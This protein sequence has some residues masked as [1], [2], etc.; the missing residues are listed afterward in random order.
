MKIVLAESLG[1]C[2]GVNRAVEATKRL[3]KEKR[4]ARVIGDIVHNEIVMKKLKD[5]GLKVYPDLSS[6][7]FSDTAENSV[8]IIRAHGASPD[9][10]DFLKRRFG[11]VVDLT[12][13]IVYNV[14]SLAK[15]LEKKGYFIVIFGKKDHAEVK[16]LCGRLNDYLIVEPGYDFETIKAF[17]RE[18]KP[19][20][21]ALISQTTM[22]SE[23]FEKLAEK[24]LKLEG[25]EVSVNNTICNVTINR[26]KMAIH[27]AQTCDAVV[28]VGG[29][30]S[31]NTGKLAKIVESHGK[32]AFHVQNPEQLPDLS[33]YRKVGIISGTSTPKEQI[34]KILDYIKFTYEG[35]VIRNGGEV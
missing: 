35:E 32:R 4:D 8:A 2:Y 25:I 16:A 34:L 26:E 27:L 15:D 7:D 3:L 14:F 1:F 31:S 20:K 5:M 10:E 18:K 19:K 28:V 13:P 24:L 29:K 17:L 22:N 11:Y 6:I 33:I 12:C 21:V 9:V 30:R 23:S